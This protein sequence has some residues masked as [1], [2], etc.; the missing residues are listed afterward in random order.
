MRK[1]ALI[2]LLAL[3]AHVSAQ[4]VDKYWISFAD[5]AA[6]S[7]YTLSNPDAYLGPR[8]LERRQHQRIIVDSLDL[9]VCQQY[10]DE[11]ARAGMRVQNRSKWLNGVSAYVPEGT[12]VS[13]LDTLPFVTEYQ[14][15]EVGDAQVPYV[16]T[17]SPVVSFAHRESYR[18]YNQNYYNS[19]YDQ[20]KQLNG[21]RMH[22]NGYEGQGVIIGVCDGG[23][24]GVDTITAFA[25]MR[26]EGRL[27]AVRDFVWEG[28]SVFSVHDHGTVVLSTMAAYDPGLFVGTAPMASYILCRTEN[29]ISETPMEEYNWVAAAEYLDSMGAD[30]ITTSLGYFYFDNDSFNHTLAGLDGRTY[31]MSRGAEIA[32]TRGMLIIN[33]AGNDG[34]SNPQHLN[35][36]ADAEHVLTVGACTRNGEWANFSSYGPTADLRI[37]PDVLALGAGAKCIGCMGVVESSNGTSL[38]TPILAGMMACFKQCCPQLTPQQMCDSARAWGHLADAPTTREGYGIP[39]FSRALRINQREGIVQPQVM[40]CLYPNPA[41]ECFVVEGIVQGKVTLYDMMGRKVKSADG[42]KPISVADL[43]AGVYIVKVTSLNGCATQ[44]LVV[45]K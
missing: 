42:E 36:P 37:K 32:F 12:D 33:A 22:V 2:V 11:L 13:F 28:D 9:P 38:A 23:F 31:V 35:S 18:P 27:L 7:E 24:P 15:L 19:G 39:D 45:E 10:I 20:I 41:S 1:I 6:P 40:A 44:R 3:T 30:I 5:K 8:A 14:L 43:V 34:Q 21:V 17:G 26:D 16:N 29:T 25:R 4:R